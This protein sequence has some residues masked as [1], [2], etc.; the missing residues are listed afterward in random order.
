MQNLN[1]SSSASRSV[2]HSN[3]TPVIIYTP[4]HTQPILPPNVPLIHPPNVPLI[5]PPNVPLMYR[6]PNVP[7]IH[8]PN[9]PLMYR[10]PNVPLMHPLQY[11]QQPINQND[12][13]TF[14]CSISNIPAKYEKSFIENFFLEQAK[15]FGEILSIN[16]TSD[17][18]NKVFQL[19]LSFNN[20]NSANNAILYFDKSKFDEC[21]LYSQLKTNNPILPNVINL[22]ILNSKLLEKQLQ[23]KINILNSIYQELSFEI[24]AG[25]ESTMIC[26]IE[27]KNSKQMNDAVKIIKLWESFHKSIILNN[28]ELDS[29]KQAYNNKLVKTC[30]NHDAHIE[31]NE[32]KPEIS[33]HSFNKETAVSVK[34]KILNFLNKMDTRVQKTFENVLH[35]EL[36][37]NALNDR[38]FLRIHELD[39]LKFEFQDPKIKN[40][41]GI[42]IAIGKRTAFKNIN[43]IQIFSMKINY[44]IVSSAN[45]PTK[46]INYKLKLFKEELNKEFICLQ[47]HENIKKND[48]F[49]IFG[50]N[51]TNV[52]KNASSIKEFIEQARSTSIVLE[53]DEQLETIKNIMKDLQLTVKNPNETNENN[54]IKECINKAINGSREFK[55]QIKIKNKLFF[56]SIEMDPKFFLSLRETYKNVK[57]FYNFRTS[58]FINLT[59]KFEEV[60]PVSLKIEMFIQNI[61]NQMITKD[62]EIKQSEAKQL[63]NLLEEIEKI[64]EKTDTIINLSGVEKCMSFKLN[65]CMIELCEG[66]ITKVDVE[67]YVNP[68]NKDLKHNDGLAKHIIDASGSHI[69]SLCNDH[70]AIVGELSDGDFFTTQAGDLGVKMNSF[71]IHIVSPIWKRGV[72]SE[73]LAKAIENCLIEANNKKCSTIAI[74]PLATGLFNYPA[75]EA[76]SIIS[77]KVVE[78]TKTKNAYLK[79]ILLISCNKLEVRQWKNNL[80]YIANLDNVKLDLYCDE[81]DNFKNWFWKDD[82]GNWKAYLH[83][84]SSIIES[85]YQTY[86]GSNFNHANST[87][88]IIIGEKNYLIDFTV[89]KQTN[90]ETKYVHDISNKIPNVIKYQWCWLD[91]SGQKSP[92]SLIHSDV[93]EN[94]YSEQ[95]SSID[96]TIKRHDNDMDEVYT[97]L[98]SRKNT[99]V[100]DLIKKLNKKEEGS[101]GIQL[102]KRTKS[103]RLIFR[104][105]VTMKSEIENRAELDKKRRVKIFISGN[106]KNLAKAWTMIN[107]LISNL[108]IMET[109]PLIEMPKHEIKKL[110]LENDAV[111][112]L[113][114][115]NI[116]IRGLPDS[117]NNIKSHLL[118]FSIQHSSVLY[119]KEWSLCQNSFNLNLVELSK[120]SNEY[121]TI[122]EEISKTIPKPE[123]V[124]IERIQNE[125][126]WRSYLEKR[127]LMTDKGL[128][129][130]NEKNLFHGTNQT[131]PEYIYDGVIGFDMRHCSGGMW[132]FGIY[133][134]VNASYSKNG[135]SYRNNDGTS[136]ILY[137]RVALGDEIELLPDK[138]YRFPP[139]K[140]FKSTKTF[141][142]ERYDSIKGY[143]NESDIYIIYENSRAYPDYKITFSN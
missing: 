56:K 33:I 2:L 22:P 52:R 108:Y 106:I 6:P 102:N 4:V 37:K 133:F 114:P 82:Q 12:R 3:R 41:I 105:E 138:N 116:I 91:D 1:R 104:E 75:Q 21:E 13:K 8:P 66:D 132:G 49:E 43:H 16:A 95:K 57:I 119:P 25:N 139:E 24:S 20:L 18:N 142:V 122:Q 117:I 26:K 59:G 121:K 32:K 100:Q 19:D 62:F 36:T 81:H 113:L 111:I 92:L 23:E 7:L 54:Q 14:T 94:A 141:T 140:P 107:D 98:F 88:N 76:L 96:I 42:I 35:Y 71:I 77:R 53:Q 55:K 34:K 101:C 29:V 115:T 11:F 103:K 48:S 130:V 127:K 72:N 135:Y 70:I 50:L 128:I 120:T 134:A 90:V 79:K 110:E 45:I 5:H 30:G 86:K 46:F 40:Q 89:W 124:K 64:K 85:K 60:E 44:S 74:P 39:K 131:D 126:L 84:Y 61:S 87:F 99:E 27:S 109:I 143:T 112:S 31:L 9:V 80:I 68:S 51:E 63:V 47:Y 58:P 129:E 28:Y 83:K 69:Q 65:N 15:R 97:F 118:D 17:A 123:I 136:S 67:A 10:P 78:F 38:E 73:S 125:W 93:I 137:C